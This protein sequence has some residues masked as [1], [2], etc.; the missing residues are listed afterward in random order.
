[1]AVIVGIG[2]W[3]HVI[4]NSEGPSRKA[5]KRLFPSAPID[6]GTIN[7][8]IVPQPEPITEIPAFSWKGK[9]DASGFRYVAAKSGRYFYR[10]DDNKALLIRADQ[11]VGYRTKDQAL[12][13]NKLPAP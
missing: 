13:D 4:S 5:V 10:I 3:I 9:V 11:F 8:R 6:Y 7:A 1:M 2:F 12:K